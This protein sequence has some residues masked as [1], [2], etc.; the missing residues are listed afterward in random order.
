MQMNSVPI[1]EMHITPVGEK[2]LDAI[3]DPNIKIILM[4]GGTRSSKTFSIMQ[5]IHI[6][7][8]SNIHSRVMAWRAKQT[9][10]R[11][12]ILH[13]WQNE[14]LIKSGLLGQ[15]KH[16]KIPPT[17]TLYQTNS[18]LEFSGLDEPQKVHGVAADLHW[19]NEAMEADQEPFKQ[20]LQRS[21]GKFILDYNPSEEEHWVYDLQKR[22]DC[23]VIH[24]TYKDNPFLPESI[25]REIEAYEDTPFNRSQGTVSEYHWNVYGL[26]LASKR[27]G[28][29]FPEFEI[30]KEWPVEAKMLGNGLDFG[31]Y[32]DPAAFGREGLL[33]GRLVLDEYFYENGLN[34]IIIP[35]REELPSIQGRLQELKISKREDI[36]AD[37]SAKSNINEL[38][39]VGYNIYPV[40]KYPGSVID[41]IELMKNYQPFYVT[42]RSVNT[43]RELKN[44]TYIK[45]PA[46]GLF[47]K[48]PIDAYNH[49]IDLFRYIAQTK[50]TK[51]NLQGIRKI[52]FKR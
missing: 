22:R 3:N 23:I 31:F 42:E 7:L 19:I 32:P 35:G 50:L 26:G 25:I 34:N 28:L 49:L 33:N 24:S 40:A 46:T 48:E 39:S 27:E 11:L 4:P 8:S 13:D 51:K 1:Y 9:W 20:L 37:S 38:K 29:I 2:L 14:F 18:T 36:I 44:Y 6:F 41:G 45:N 5:N 21:R 47:L 30:I 16:I 12:S 52:S 10:V 17:F 43:I 15:Y